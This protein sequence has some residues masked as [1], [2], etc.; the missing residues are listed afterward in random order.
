[1]AFPY[2]GEDP[3]AIP[4]KANYGFIR[5]HSSCHVTAY[6]RVIIKSLSKVSLYVRYP[7]FILI[8]GKQIWRFLRCTPLFPSCLHNLDHVCITWPYDSSLPLHML[9]PAAPERTMA[10]DF[11]IAQGFA[12]LDFVNRLG[13]TLRLHPSWRPHCGMRQPI[14]PFQPY[15]LYSIT[16][17]GRD[18]LF[19]FPG[20]VRDQTEAGP[21]PSE[22]ISISFPDPAKQ[23]N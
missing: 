2:H 10:G 8:S 22:S 19:P 11:N 9:L 14:R 7:Y 13:S 23:S 17:E 21:K 12:L 1:M 18:L 5:G 20:Y 15:F 16:E 6:R 3:V 4:D